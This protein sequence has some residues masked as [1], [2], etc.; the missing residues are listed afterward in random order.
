[1]TC[2]ASWDPPSPPWPLRLPLGRCFLA[3]PSLTSTQ[4]AFAHVPGAFALAVHFA[5]STFPLSTQTSCFSP[6]GPLLKCHLLRD[7]LLDCPVSK[8]P[9]AVTLCHLPRLYF[10]P[11]AFPIQNDL[12]CVSST[13]SPG[14]PLAPRGQGFCLPR[15]LASPPCPTPRA[16]PA[17]RRSSRNVCGSKA[18]RNEG[19]N[20]Q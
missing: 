2:T 4:A 8:G 1:M 14:K 9:P 20:V 18:Q 7:A 19:A 12:L 11:G 10:H 13:V 3:I 6:F 16:A 17:P 5:R 15:F